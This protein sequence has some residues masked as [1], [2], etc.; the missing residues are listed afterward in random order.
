MCWLI[1]KCMRE[2]SNAFW[3]KN[4]LALN[5]KAIFVADFFFSPDKELRNFKII[6]CIAKRQ[7][8]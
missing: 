1:Y 8:A 7:F 4:I 3:G 5:D 2:M 6:A